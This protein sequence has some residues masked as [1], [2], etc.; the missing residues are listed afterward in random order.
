MSIHNILYL[1]SFSTNL[2][3]I[4][5]WLYI[6]I[7]LFSV[8]TLLVQMFVCPT[9]IR[10][11]IFITCYIIL[12]EIVMASKL[13]LYLHCLFF[14][15]LLFGFS[16]RFLFVWNKNVVSVIDKAQTSFFLEHIVSHSHA[17][18]IYIITNANLKKNCNSTQRWSKFFIKINKT[19]IQA[20]QSSSY[21]TAWPPPP[22][23]KNYFRLC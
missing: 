10:K 8:D 17:Y 14:K 23:Q 20:F 19:K 13:W 21:Y 6:Y 16:G 5:F 3:T 12:K 15:T 7:L 1:S 22:G 11:C 9:V 4:M 2:H 18:T